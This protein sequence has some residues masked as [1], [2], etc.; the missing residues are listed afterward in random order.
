[1]QNAIS[2]GL[3][4]NHQEPRVITLS[5]K[6]VLKGEK[7]RKRDTCEREAKIEKYNRPKGRILLMQTPM[8]YFTFQFTQRSQRATE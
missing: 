6:R 1:M 8:D 7:I 2:L 5:Q 4:L 3:P